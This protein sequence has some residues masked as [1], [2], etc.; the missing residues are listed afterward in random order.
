[1]ILLVHCCLVD[2]CAHCLYI[3][4][5]DLIY[6]VNT[7]SPEGT[8]TGLGVFSMGDSLPALNPITQPLQT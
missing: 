5:L 8:K 7:K 3:E 6:L 2:W 4:R 1:M